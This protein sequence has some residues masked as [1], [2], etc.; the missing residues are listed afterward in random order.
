VFRLA[1][2]QNGQTAI[3]RAKLNEALANRDAAAK[4]WLPDLWVGASWYRLDGG[5]ANPDGSL[6]HASYSSMFAGTEICSAFD[7]RE[8]AYKKVDAERRIWQQRAEVSKLTSDALMDASTTYVDLLAAR[9]AEAV[10]VQVQ[11]YLEELFK[12]T[13]A[14]ANTLPAAEV[15]VARIQT[16]LQAQQLLL[17][18][19]REGAN[20][21][22]IKLI[23]EL[24]L[25]PASDLVPV[26]R[27][28]AALALVNPDVPV[29]ELV[30]RAL[31]EGPAVR[32]MEGM[33]NLIHQA[34]EKASGLAK[35]LPVFD[36]RL[37]E[38]GFGTGPG[39]RMDW[40]NRFDFGIHIKWN[41]TELALARDKQRANQARI[42]QAHLTYQDLK[43][44][45]T[46]GV[47]EAREAVQS[48]R[49]Q[50]DLAEQQL[51]HANNAYE[52]SKQRLMQ[53]PNLK[54][55]SP[56]EVLL[57]LRSLNGAHLAY[58][59]AIRDYDKAQLRLFVLTGSAHED[60]RH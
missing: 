19:M 38:G 2:S 59:M 47:Q 30:A 1:E 14:I 13:K 22:A 15:D 9:A 33:L 35:Y 37:A 39:D 7:L 28:L 40:D 25:D 32:E 56:S 54:D 31:A 46:M 58:V 16:E 8:F 12:Q 44:K 20:S 11:G 18:K 24:G 17:R 3:A 55:R 49:E 45:L 60:C 5:T 42:D 48:G 50:M 51:K 10:V 57:A 27:Q 53:A 4:A 6:L 34:Q 26:D 29:E 36:V 43:A 21:A 23:Y 41:L 52:R